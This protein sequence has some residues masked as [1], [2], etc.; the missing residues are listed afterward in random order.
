VNLYKDLVTSGETMRFKDEAGML[1]YIKQYS[2]WFAKHPTDYRSQASG[3]NTAPIE[4][5][6]AGTPTHEGR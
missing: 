3:P 2:G 4:S 5:A 1:D 6:T